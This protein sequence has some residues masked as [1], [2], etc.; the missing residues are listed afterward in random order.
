LSRKWL[1]CLLTDCLP[2]S[3]IVGGTLFYM[4]V[5]VLHKWTHLV[6]P[7]F[8]FKVLL[9]GNGVFKNSIIMRYYLMPN[10]CNVM[11]REYKFNK[12]KK[13]F[14]QSRLICLHSEILTTVHNF[15]VTKQIN[16]LQLS[17]VLTIHFRNSN[18]HSKRF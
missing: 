9:N 8:V 5:C 16:D 11:I 7:V 3:L 1:K 2:F 10:E 15:S 18:M 6:S 12:S 17:I 4:S 14:R 13:S